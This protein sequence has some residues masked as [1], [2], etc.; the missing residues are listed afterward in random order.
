MLSISQSVNQ[1][2]EVNCGPRS[3]VIVLS[4][5]KHEIQVNVKTFAHATANVSE[6]GTASIHLDV[7]S[8]M[9]KI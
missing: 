4:T 5:L 8:M 7:R 1:S 2:E 9:V 6:S 3:E